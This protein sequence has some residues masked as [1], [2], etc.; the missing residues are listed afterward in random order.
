MLS[1]GIPWNM[2]RVTYIFRSECIYEENT[3]DMMMMARVALSVIMK[4]KITAINR[5]PIEM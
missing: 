5:G 1:S 2:P 3:S 4:Y